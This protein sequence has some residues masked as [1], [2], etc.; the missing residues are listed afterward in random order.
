MTAE[1]RQ[2]HAGGCVR[3][4]SR[5]SLSEQG[6]AH[7]EATQPELV[8]DLHRGPADRLVALSGLPAVACG[9]LM[10]IG[11][12]F[13][14]GAPIPTNVTACGDGIHTA[15]MPWGAPQDCVCDRMTIGDLRSGPRFVGTARVILLDAAMDDVAIGETRRISGRVVRP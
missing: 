8:P 11:V 10:V 7:G 13:P 14:P 12:G 1:R 6:A 4:A 2:G 9:A 15:A 5:P 3:D